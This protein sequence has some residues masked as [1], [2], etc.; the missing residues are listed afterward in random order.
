[1]RAIIASALG[2]R[3]APQQRPSELL[4]WLAGVAEREI[5]V[6]EIIT[7]IGNRAFGA[8]ILLF[9]IPVLLPM[10]AGLSHIMGA[11]LIFIASQ[12][13]LGREFLWLPAFL[14]ERRIPLSKIRPGLLRIAGML[15]WAENYLLARHPLFCTRWANRLT[16]AACL[17][18]S[19]I[20]LI[21]IPFSSLI[22]AFAL[23][24]FSLGL[25]YRDGVMIAFGWLFVIL[26]SIV[27]HFVT[28]C[29]I[30][31]VTQLV[32]AQSC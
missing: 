13:M 32:S 11:P 9:A 21:P 19:L 12:L 7:S 27:T 20:L 25:I 29:M 14:S 4:R 26:A 28:A 1:M 8:G 18:L 10:P 17:V 15:N 2:T 5:A 23:T 30:S 6:G 3:G 31:V 24:V 16:G 22:P